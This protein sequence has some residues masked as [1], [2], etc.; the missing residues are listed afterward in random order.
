MNLC[1]QESFTVTTPSAPTLDRT[2]GQLL[3]TPLA[4]PL[5][6]EDQARADL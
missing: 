4:P 2:A 3:T 1:Q 5:S 6:G